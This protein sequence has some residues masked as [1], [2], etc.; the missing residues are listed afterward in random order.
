MHADGASYDADHLHADGVNRRA[1]P[2][3]DRFCHAFQPSAGSY[4]RA[5]RHV[6]G[7]WSVQAAQ[8][9]V[10]GGSTCLPTCTAPALLQPLPQQS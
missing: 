9:G 10:V 7:Q 3:D 5:P 8:A 1:P 6:A 4:G 2:R